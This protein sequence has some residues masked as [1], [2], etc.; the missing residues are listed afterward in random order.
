MIEGRDERG[1][2][3]PEMVSPIRRRLAQWPA[4]LLLGGLGLLLV[5]AALAPLIF[6]RSSPGSLLDRA[7]LGTWQ[8]RM[9]GCPSTRSKQDAQ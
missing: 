4:R 5:G 3:N 6:S 7:R 8:A 9:L 2:R 1:Q